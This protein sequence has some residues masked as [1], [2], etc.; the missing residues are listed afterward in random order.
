VGENLDSVASDVPLQARI[1]S[2]GATQLKLG[3]A[4]IAGVTCDAEAHYLKV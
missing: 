4:R 1:C 2:R 3:T